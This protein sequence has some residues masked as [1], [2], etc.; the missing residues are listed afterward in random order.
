MRIVALDFETANMNKDS[1]I[2]IGLVKM[3]GDKVLDKYYSLIKPP[4]M[5]FEESFKLIHGLCEEDVIDA[6]TFDLIYDDVVSFIGDDLVIAHNAGFDT[7]V[8][9]ECCKTYNIVPKDFIYLCTLQLS[10]KLWPDEPSH[11]L[12]SL[13]SKNNLVY[14]AH[15]ALEDSYACGVLFN[16]LVGDQEDSTLH[17]FLIKQGVSV[18]KLSGK[19]Y[20]KSL[21]NEQISFF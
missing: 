1:A 10:R 13:S 11:K 12:T 14:K 21:V 9:V 5:V 16:K 18:K 2:S 20:K 19:V 6:P 17:Q 8:F 3:D 4:T 15:D 7:R